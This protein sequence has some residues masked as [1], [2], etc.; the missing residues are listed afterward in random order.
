MWYRRSLIY[1]SFT[2][3]LNSKYLINYVH[4][5]KQFNKNITQKVD[6]MLAFLFFFNFFHFSVF[7]VFFFLFFFS[8]KQGESIEPFQLLMYSMFSFLFTSFFG[9]DVIDIPKEN[10]KTYRTL[11]YIFIA[12]C[13]SPVYELFL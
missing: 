4:H 9:Y 11:K 1:N 6:K 8:R 12:R 3:L 7:L 5:S 13:A 2:T 10:E